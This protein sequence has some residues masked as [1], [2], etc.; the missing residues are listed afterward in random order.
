MEEKDIKLNGI[1]YHYLEYKNPG[2]PKILFIHGVIVESH[3]WEKIISFI[4]DDFHIYAIDQKGHGKSDDGMSYMKDYAPDIIT[5]D[6]H[7]FY[8]KVIN[9]PFYLVG[10]SLGGQ[11]SI[12]YA[13]TYPHT[14]KGLI[15][16]ESLPSLSLKALLTL[17]KVDK[18]TP[19]SFKSKEEVTAF[20]NQAKL[21]GVSEYTLKYVMKKNEDGEYVLRYDRKHIN[22]KTLIGFR[23]R[24]KQ[25]WR[26]AKNILA[27]TL[28]VKAEKSLIVDFNYLTTMKKIIKNSKFI[29]IKNAG[30]ELVFGFPKEVASDLKQFIKEI[31]N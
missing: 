16:L 22:P 19:K 25:L 29:E 11:F 10:H 30:H 4:K 5:E 9:E 2:K 24:N 23:I 21:E 31:P 13:G 6:L 7:Q 26:K 15:I 14:L 27:P 20:Y 3:C 28:I 1:N 18:L 8:D 12:A 17:G